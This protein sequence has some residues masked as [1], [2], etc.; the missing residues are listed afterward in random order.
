[1]K[2]L[3]VLSLGLAMLTLTGCTTES[4]VE[5][6][7][8]TPEVSFVL[9]DSG[10]TRY[11]DLEG[12]VI[13][14]PA[15]GEALYGQDAQYVGVEQ[16]FT[17]NGD[18][19]IT[20]NNTGFMWQQT[21]EFDRISFDEA[22]EYVE[23][24]ELGGYDDWRLPTIDE[25]YSIANFDG[26]LLLEGDSTP[27]L[28]TDY[29]Y[30][31]YDRMAFA[32]QFWSSTLYIGGAIT[33]METQGAFGFNFA[34]G[35]IKAY[36][37]GYYFDGTELD[38]QEPGCFVLAVRGEENV[39][40]VNDFVDNGDE[41]VTDQATGL[42]WSSLSSDEGMDWEAALEY[43]ESSEYAG[44]SDWRLPSAKELQS[45]I[46]YDSTEI[47]AL[48]EDFFTIADTDSYV[49]TSTTHGDFKNTAIYLAVGKA[50]SITDSLDEFYD[51]HGAG[52][53]RSDPK[54]GDPDDYNMASVNAEDLVRIYN[55]VFLVRDAD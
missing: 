9:T 41:T 55:Y 14:A 44:Y 23:N 1:M 21:S 22:K 7:I 39:Y 25:L 5:V 40:G 34:D 24:L 11:F 52:A 6:D 12:N 38:G 15:E 30:F 54:A 48:D 49:W 28:D 46:D 3:L 17:D 47:P 50:Y 32:G 20:D 10:Q 31:E 13:D 33:D 36:G 53:Q 37:T 35:H 27:Y 8:E 26:E 42:M 16:S 18:G 4:V 29:F 51:W 43:A 2:K 45:I 19:T